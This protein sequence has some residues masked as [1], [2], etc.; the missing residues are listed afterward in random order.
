MARPAVVV[1]DMIQDNLNEADAPLTIQAALVIPAIRRL[2]DRARS[3]KWPVVFA[4]DS[5][6][7]D[8]F[9]FNSHLRP[10]ALR[11]TKGVRVID[12]LAPRRGDIIL[13]KRRLSAFFKTDLD[14]TLRTLG[15]DV[16]AVAGLTTPWC[17]LMTAVE[18]LCHDFRAVIVE[19]C[20]CAHKPEIHQAVVELYRNSVLSPLFQ[21]LNL[22]GFLLM[23]REEA[24]AGGAAEE[25][26][27]ER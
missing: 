20:C 22:D 26:S 25:T 17:V 11:G 9:I 16:V 7:K 24:D 23:V 2:L 3:E 5:F 21:V 12:D 19:D 1:V 8:D 4:C 10:H 18:A 6:L 13:E 27:H 14:Q 15:V